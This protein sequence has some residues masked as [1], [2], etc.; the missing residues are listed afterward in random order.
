[1]NNSKIALE[2]ESLAEEKLV[3]YKPM[4]RQRETDLAEI[5]EALRNIRASSYWKVL[6]AKVFN[7]E[8]NS[9]RDK[10]ENEKNPTE[11]Y[12]LQGRITQAKKLNLDKELQACEMEL[13]RIK[14]QINAN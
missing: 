14:D 8:F 7:K 9:L 5:I 1:M 3:D 11:I 10:L 13:K 2:Y 12:R 4:L 6:E